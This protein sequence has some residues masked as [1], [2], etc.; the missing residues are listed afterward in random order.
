MDPHPST[1]R[2]KNLWK[3]N[4]VERPAQSA[5]PPCNED[6]VPSRDPGR[7]GAGLWA[8]LHPETACVRTMGRRQRQKAYS[9]P[10]PPTPSATCPT[11]MS[12]QAGP[13][14]PSR[15]H[16]SSGVTRLG[17][18]NPGKRQRVTSSGVPILAWAQL[19]ASH[20]DLP[21]CFEL[22]ANPRACNLLTGA[23][24]NV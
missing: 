1:T 18:K 23:P 13:R 21:V 3:R 12:Q 9:W 11:L 22:G 24:S 8:L 10:C 20:G 2:K 14:V 4:W 17:H 6:A 7:A 15:G 16:G 5:R 19:P